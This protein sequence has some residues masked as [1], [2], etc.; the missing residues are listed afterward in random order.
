MLIHRSQFEK[1]VA[2]FFFHTFLSCI[3]T[4]SPAVIDQ[5]DPSFV[6]VSVFD[7]TVLSRSKWRPLTF[8]LYLVEEILIW[9]SQIRW[10]LWLLEKFK[11][12]FLDD[13]MKE[14]CVLYSET[15]FNFPKQKKHNSYQLY[16][17]KSW[18]APPWTYQSPLKQAALLLHIYYYIIIIMTIIIFCSHVW[19]WFCWYCI[20]ITL[21]ISF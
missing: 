2:L 14:D 17:T 15:I 7:N 3:H 11:S 19:L 10:T 8:F 6:E 18:T 1:N 20:W 21:C 16:H 9:G 12:T 5:T 4:L 13:L